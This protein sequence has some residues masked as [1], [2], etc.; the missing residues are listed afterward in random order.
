MKQKPPELH[1]NSEASIFHFMSCHTLHN[2]I[3]TIHRNS[4]FTYTYPLL[5]EPVVHIQMR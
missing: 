3:Q 1:V 5:V 2:A 4:K